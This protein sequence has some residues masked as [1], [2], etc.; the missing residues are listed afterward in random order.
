M[1]RTVAQLRTP[2]LLIDTPTFEANLAAMDAVLPGSRLRPHVKA[3]KSTT[4]AR[5]LAEGGHRSFCAA[6][7]REIEG[8]VAAGLVDDLLLANETLDTARL[9]AL[10]ERANIT[11]AVDSRATIEAAASGGVRSVLIDV[12]VGL[13]RCG[14]EPAEAPALAKLARS[15]GL[16]VRGVM[17]YEGHLMMVTDRAERAQRTA[18]AMALLTHA[19]DVV[20]GDVVSC[21]GTGIFDV[22]TS[23]TEIQAGSYALLD[24][25][26]DTLDL[27]FA[28]ALSVLATVISVSAK[29]WIIADA[30]LKAFGMDHGNPS[31]D[32]G[33]V[34]FCSDEHITLLPTDAVS[35]NGAAWKVGDRVRLWP[36]HVDPTV[37][38]HERYHLV[39]G[40]DVVD[41]W[42]IDLRHW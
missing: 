7:P 17:G 11:V 30:G 24:T 16:E 4:L 40:D 15:S 25:D 39:D 12:N 9:G 2:A 10:S 21:G 28:K 27:P 37:A 20:G 41:E 32:D 22:N 6:T 29:G 5:H 35:S 26:Y 19:A 34:F 8:L 38:R 18:E 1:V 33:E 42:E 13:P 31:W 36:A 23:C 14:C 3:T